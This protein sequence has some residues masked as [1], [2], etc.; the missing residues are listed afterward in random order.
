MKL[1]AR[2]GAEFTRKKKQNQRD[3]FLAQITVV[4]LRPTLVAALL[5]YYSK[6]EGRGRSPVD[7]DRI[8]LN[9]HR[10]VMLWPIGRRHRGRD[11]RYLGHSLTFRRRSDA[12]A[13]A[14]RND[15]ALVTPLALAAQP[16]TPNI[17]RISRHIAIK[18]LVMREG[19]IVDTTLIADTPSN[20]N[21]DRTRDPEM[22]QSKKGNN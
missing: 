3:R 12:R 17:R 16:D 8:L 15:A 13:G 5:P 6:G 11:L 14:G 22:Q 1:T 18:G 20:K 21:R 9:L 2:S 7:L 4:M 19:L 10:A